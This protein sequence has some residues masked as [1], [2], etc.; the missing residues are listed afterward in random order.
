MSEVKAKEYMKTDKERRGEEKEGNE[1]RKRVGGG[2]EAE[3]MG[4]EGERR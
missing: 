1:G 2:E 3:G 4:R